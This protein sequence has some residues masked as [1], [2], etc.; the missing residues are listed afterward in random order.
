MHMAQH[1]SLKEQ[2]GTLVIL[3]CGGPS[4]AAERSTLTSREVC[5]RQ[6][7]FNTS[8]GHGIAEVWAQHVSAPGGTLGGGLIH[9]SGQPPWRPPQRW[10][11]RL[12]RLACVKE[13]A[14]LSD[15]GDAPSGCSLHQNADQ[16]LLLSGNCS[17]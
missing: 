14:Y 8:T 3:L 10:P 16:C 11:G 7:R 13:N 5:V 2:G 17:W 15:V 6:P 4:E 9:S 12:D 1:S